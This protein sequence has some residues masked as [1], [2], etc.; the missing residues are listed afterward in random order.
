LRALSHILLVEDNSADVKLVE[1]AFE[2]CNGSIQLHVVRDG[3]EATN[4]VFRLDKFANAPRPDLI[5]LDLNLPKKPGIDVLSEIKADPTLSAIPILIFTTSLS[6]EEIRRC[7]QHHANTYITKPSE[8]DE[9][10]STIQ[11]IENYWL[12]KAQLP[13]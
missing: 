3:L 7:Y 11:C 4:F 12:R 2:S 6:P 1:K 8:L 10:F 13:S 5:I 9:F